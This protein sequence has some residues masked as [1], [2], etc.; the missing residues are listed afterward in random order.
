M[1]RYDKLAKMSEQSQNGPKRRPLPY[2]SRHRQ[3]A[4]Q[5]AH[6]EAEALGEVQAHPLV[7]P[8]P[9]TL[10]TTADQLAELGAHL[11]QAGLFAY[12]SEFIGELTYIPRLCLIQVATSDRV[13]LIDPL[14]DLDLRPFW[15]LLCDG[16]IEKIVHAGQQDLEPVFRN[17][18]HSPANVLDVQITAGMA[19]LPYP[20][21]LA[22]LVRQI[23][24]IKIGKGL[25]FTRWDQRPLSAMQLRY[26]AD[27]VRYL[28]AV[29][30]G[31]KKLL[32]D[33]WRWAKEESES[34]CDQKLYTT[35][36]ATQYLRIRG[37][38]GLSPSGQVV[39]RELVNWRDESAR[40]HDVPAR[41]LVRDDVLMDMA[42]QPIHD[43]KQLARVKGLP[44][45]IEAQYGN[46]LVARTAR[47]LALPRDQW[48]RAAATDEDPPAKFEADALWGL[49]QCLSAGR[50]IDPALITSRQEVGQLARAL[51]AGR[52]TEDFRLMKGWRREAVGEALLKMVREN[53]G[54][55]MRWEK[56]RL[57]SDVTQ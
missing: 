29:Y 2:Q 33:K 30:A 27:D 37:A 14:A 46:E 12:D 54:A 55:A 23:L 22:K 5:D 57:Q 7:C 51:R 20:L 49:I 15:E 36:P 24:D 56:G 34:Y 9:P 47:A 32:D 52:P 28:P 44:R 42:R 13:A 17:I 25:T 39:L 1:R 38:I 16:A 6:A 35:D 3:S 26:A 8:D 4:H 41:S 43:V 48:P 53:Q 11:R 19:S 21:S 40:A 18:G 31:L 50:G 10:I 45:P